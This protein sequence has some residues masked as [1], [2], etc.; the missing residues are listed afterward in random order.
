MPAGGGGG[1]SLTLLLLLLLLLLLKQKKSSRSIATISTADRFFVFV[2]TYAP[3][4][5]S[6]RPWGCSILGLLYV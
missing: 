3:A 1:G 6:V 5:W 2:L 4:H